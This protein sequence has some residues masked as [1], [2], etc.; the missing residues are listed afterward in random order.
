MS[1]TLQ[2]NIN[3]LHTDTFRKMSAW[4]GGCASHIGVGIAVRAAVHDGSP[5]AAC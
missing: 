4:Y 1:V 5:V 3:P 2:G